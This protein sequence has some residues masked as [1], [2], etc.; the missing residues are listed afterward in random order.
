[1]FEATSWDSLPDM[2][3][4]GR[5]NGIFTPTCPGWAEWRHT[6]VPC[7]GKTFSLPCPVW[8][9]RI[10]TL[11]HVLYGSSGIHSDVS[12]ADQVMYTLTCPDQAMYTLTCPTWT[13]C[14][15][16]VDAWMISY[17]SIKQTSHDCDHAL[18][19]ESATPLGGPD[20]CLPLPFNVL[21]MIW[22]DY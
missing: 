13:G 18:V 6:Y 10:H 17:G 5:E 1:M 16:L 9:E 4:L 3:C 19:M 20:I 14:V 8:T 11:W 12:S 2:S 22:L 21:E 7:V 15:A